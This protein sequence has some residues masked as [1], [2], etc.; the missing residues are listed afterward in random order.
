M[1]VA[2]FSE[3]PK[4]GESDSTDVAAK[5]SEKVNTRMQGPPAGGVF[6]AEGPSDDG[7][8]WVFDVWESDDAYRTFQSEVLNP[9]LADVGVAEPSARVL[10]VSW[11]SSQMD[12][13]S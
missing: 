12:P 2:Y 3:W 7:G 6:H 4:L 11:N 10:Q 5:I 8:W 9:V 13:S 1:S